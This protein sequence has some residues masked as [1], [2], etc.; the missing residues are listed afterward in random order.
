MAAQL[1]AKWL[2]DKTRWRLDFTVE[3]LNGKQVAGHDPV[4]C[5]SIVDQP[6]VTPS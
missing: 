5:F 1:E 3:A 2:Y 6:G 4:T